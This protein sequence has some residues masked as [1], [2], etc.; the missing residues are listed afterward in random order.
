MSHVDKAWSNPDS[1]LQWALAFGPFEQ[2]M[3]AMS[4]ARSAEIL[5]LTQHATIPNIQ[6]LFADG[7]LTVTELTVHYLKRIQQYDRPRLN[8]ILELNPDAL[9]IAQACDQD[10]QSTI[11]NHP[12]LHGIP[13]L[14][15]GNIGTGDQM[16][17]TAGAAVLAGHRL[18]RDAFIVRQ[19]REAGAVILGKT[20]MSEWAYF[21]NRNAPSGYSTLGGHTR[22]AY[23]R[24]DCGGSS[25]GS[26][27]AVS[28]EF[29]PIAIGTETSGSL[30][31]PSTQNSLYT[32][33][34]SLGLIS[35]DRIVPI[36]AAQDTAG[37]MTK[38]V[39]DL[40][41]LLN[42]MRGVDAAD[43]LTQEAAPLADTD[44]TECLD[45]TGLQGVRIGLIL[46]E[47]ATLPDD[48]SRPDFADALVECDA[49]IQEAV[50]QLE[51]AGAIVKRVPYQARGLNYLDVL[52]KGMRYDLTD[53]LVATDAPVKSLEEIVAFNEEHLTERAYY[54]QEWLEESAEITTSRAEYA[55]TTAYNRQSSRDH[56]RRQLLLHKVDMFMTLAN[57]GSAEYCPAGTPAVCIPIGYRPSGRPQS[58]TLF[59]DFLDDGKL[60][61]AAYAFEQIKQRRV[62]PTMNNANA[63]S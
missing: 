36:T 48:E 58:M 4:E 9:R 52:L 28:A 49:L 30:T 63:S 18:D 2:A 24:F 6:K 8:S 27:V 14:L 21:M 44:F 32:L 29:A 11:R 16:H 22:N 23:G 17:T 45:P 56:I 3:G 60:I 42:G 35:R 54:A 12:F 15:K 38:T 61:A 1:P 50:A 41:I 34:P 31:S 13:V 47:V 33:K 43:P 39:T 20:N 10:R 46:P 19:L 57:W 40:A 55:I 26:G 51:Q 53:Y 7:Q 62:P 5:T 59:S 37:P 25:S